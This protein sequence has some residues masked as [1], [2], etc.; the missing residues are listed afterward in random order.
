MAVTARGLAKA[1]EILVGEFTLVATNVPFLKRGY[2]E[3]E[4]GNW[5]EN[6][7]EIGK[8]N[9]ATAMLVRANEMAIQGGS[10]ALV[11]QQ[12]WRI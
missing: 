5:I 8:A 6:H 11:I 9:I 10:V 4:L 7:Y 3:Q 2:Q 1:A 12:S